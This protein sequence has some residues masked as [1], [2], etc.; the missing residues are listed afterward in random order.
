MF[1]I[2]SYFK[3]PFAKMVEV[4][5]AYSKVSS[6]FEHLSALAIKWCFQFY[7]LL[8]LLVSFYLVLQN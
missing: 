2:E 1:D 6:L 3:L 8:W 7:K 4:Y 5:Q